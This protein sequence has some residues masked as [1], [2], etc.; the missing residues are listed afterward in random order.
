MSV[1]YS[2]MD[3]CSY[4]ADEVNQTF[5]KLTTEGVSMFNYSNADNP[6]VAL[7]DAVAGFVEPGVELYNIDAC[8]VMYDATTYKF[9]ISPGNAFM[10]DGST[11]TI[12]TEP[13]DITEAVEQ[14]RKSSD[15]DIWVCFYRNI[16]K[17][18][19]DILVD[20]DDTVFNSEYSVQLGKISATNLIFDMRKI[21]KTKIAPCSANVIQELT[22]NLGTLIYHDSGYKLRRVI[23]KNVFP[24]ASKVFLN[25]VVR[26]IQKVDVEAGEKL[27]YQR[28]WFQGVSSEIMI[29]FNLTAEGL[30]VWATQPYDS[31]TPGN[32]NIIIF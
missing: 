20:T 3:D 30:E 13:Y 16:P 26:D 29:A 7:N 22:I 15:G 5:S 32:W 23:I 11:I 31:A 24:G 17:N 12:D 19:I 27:N 18:C 9:T 6:L 25:G 28:A 4:G 10:I 2:F 14:I 8:R 21:A 1:T